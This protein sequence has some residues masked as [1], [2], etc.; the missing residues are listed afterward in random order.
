MGARYAA[1]LPRPSS[2]SPSQA[3]TLLA[4]WHSS[5]LWFTQLLEDGSALSHASAWIRDSTTPAYVRSACRRS[6]DDLS[7]C[8]SVQARRSSTGGFDDL[9]GLVRR[10]LPQP[11]PPSTGNK[12]NTHGTQGG[13]R[14]HRR[15]A[16]NPQ[17]TDQ[18]EEAG[19]HLGVH[20]D[21]DSGTSG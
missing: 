3:V 7:S 16:A 14:P 5:R 9:D 13:K 19:H 2:E 4:R 1:T 20:T 21:A 10:R 11:V 6:G 18:H 17:T 8:I 15:R 12:H